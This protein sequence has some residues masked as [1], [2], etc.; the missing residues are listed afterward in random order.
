MAALNLMLRRQGWRLARRL[1]QRGASSLLLGLGLVLLL[2]TALWRADVERRWRAHEAGSQAAAAA[3]AAAVTDPADR[4]GALLRDFYQ[5]L[6]EGDEMPVVL[7]DL[8]DL[9]ERHGLRLLR[10]NYR[11]E[12]DG[13]AALARYRMSLPLRGDTAQVQRFVQSA[14]LAHATLA[15]DSIQFKREPQSGRALE[16]RVQ[17]VLFVRPSGAAARSEP[18]PPTAQ[19]ALATAAAASAAPAGPP[20]EPA[21][22]P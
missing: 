10:G 14:L 21:H 19:A 17:W 5:A 1:R 13:A 9:A 11:M 22:K 4:R 3:A 16:A 6:P 8:I 12:V 18:A 2:A 15:I 7:Q 20:P